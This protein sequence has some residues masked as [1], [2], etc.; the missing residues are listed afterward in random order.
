[1][2]TSLYNSI[3]QY[4][5]KFSTTFYE[6]PKKIIGE[7]DIF[8]SKWRPY[9]PRKKPGR[10]G[11]SVYSLDGGFSGIPDL[12]SIREYCIKHQVELNELS[13]KE[14]TEA[15]RVAAT[16]IE[17][18]EGHVGRSHFIRMDG[19]GFFPPHR[20]DKSIEPKSFRLLVPLMDMNPPQTWFMLDRE[21]LLFEHGRAYFINTCM[22]HTVFS[23]YPSLFLVLNIA[24]NE[25]T[26]STLLTN[27]EWK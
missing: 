4:G 24:V 22:E 8:S 14:P 27:M 10:E 11:L 1:V 6:D 13:F 25:D 3:L 2:T 12:D 20:D 5:T 15:A 21:A 16:Y 17:P 19:G 18:F 26:V 7:L 9:N 23:C